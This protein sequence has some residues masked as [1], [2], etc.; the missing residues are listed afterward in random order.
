MNWSMAFDER[1]DFRRHALLP[2][3][4]VAGV[5]EVRQ[6]V[7]EQRIVGLERLDQSFLFGRLGNEPAEAAFDRRALEPP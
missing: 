4:V 2:A 3:E 5:R 7:L 6:R 1:A